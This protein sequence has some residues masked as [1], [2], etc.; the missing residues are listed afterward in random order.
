MT[1]P[2][3]PFSAIVGLDDAKLALLLNAVDPSVGGVLLY[4][5]VGSGRTTLVRSLPRLL[6][7]RAPLVTV[8]VGVT[9]TEL[10][11]SADRPGL[12]ASAH[13]GV[14]YV[15]DVA[16]QSGSVLEA[17]VDVAADGPARFVLTGGA[18]ETE[19]ER[20]P[21]PAWILD[22][23][24]LAVE[25]SA[26][27]DPSLRA[28]AVARR[29]TYEVDP[30]RFAAA[31]QA[32]DEELAMKL[33]DARPA[34]LPAELVR[35]V[36]VLCTRLG[37]AGLRGDLTICRAA[38]ALA[39]WDRRRLA[40]VVDVRRVAGLALAHRCRRGPW[41]GPL[42]LMA[43]ADAVDDCAAAMPA[44]P[45]SSSPSVARPDPALPVPGPAVPAPPPAPANATSVSGP[46]DDHLVAGHAP[47]ATSGSSAPSGSSPPAPGDLLGHLIVLAVD[48]SATSGTDA[49]VEAA[50]SAIFDYLGDAHRRDLLALVVYR[51]FAAEVVLRPT[52]SVEIARARLTR[53]PTGGKAPLAEGI[54]TALRIATLP[55]RAATHQ[56]V[57]I[58][59][60]GGRATHAADGG[61]PVAAAIGAARQVAR[62]GIASFVV[63]VDAMHKSPSGIGPQL[64]EA[65][66]GRYIK[67]PTLAGG[68]LDRVLRQALA[69]SE[70]SQ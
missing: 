29:L 24:G 64:A 26:P 20:D 18:E 41:D 38:A 67:L 22:R 59:L 28:E 69:I 43:I 7:S 45:V 30:S 39:G 63:E 15:E 48:T 32:A 14:L 37:A 16:H 6:G 3:F 47:P 13:G 68:E 60:S 11:G 35:M 27:A 56:P 19:G 52:S 70:G 65:M 50:K 12:L 10:Y 57:I 54:S 62:K 61:D 36:S 17:V 40:G 42:D 46:A 2:A 21:V 1:R 9:E 23:F 8:P 33:G 34:S 55:G 49:R 66:A 51:G 5:P 53:L 25:V 44:A 31:W 58:V 4:G